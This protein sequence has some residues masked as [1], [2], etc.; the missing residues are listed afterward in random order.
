MPAG[1]QARS[2]REDGITLY[3]AT[4][5][6]GYVAD[7]TGGVDWLEAFQAS[8]DDGDAD[9]FAAFFETVDCLAMGATTYEQV[10]GF[11]EWPYG[12]RPTYVFTH[13]DLPSATGAVRFVDGDVGAVASDLRRRY[14]HVWVVGGAHLARSFLRHREVDTVRLSFVPVL[15][16]EGVR[17]FAGDYD[18]RRL[19]LVGTTVRDIG[20]VEHRY[21][22]LE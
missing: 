20:V 8:A 22:V 19:R 18:G 2:V 11:G 16:G 13:R 4:S 9:G 15:L 5:V 21:E 3:V 14:D 1:V 7:A 12:D 6:D 10:L 17:L